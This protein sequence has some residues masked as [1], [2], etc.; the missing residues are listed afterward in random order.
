M[1]LEK[2]LAAVM[3]EMS[4]LPNESFPAQNI[5]PLLDLTLLDAQATCPQ[6]QA[7]SIKA[8][9][10]S[11]AAV[12]VLPD[13]LQWIP[14]AGMDIRRATVINFP[15]GNF[16]QKEVFKQFENIMNHQLV[17]EIDYVFPYQKYLDN[18]PSEALKACEQ[19]YRACSDHQIIFKVILETG[20]FPSCEL[21][22]QASR[23]VLAHGCDFLKTSTGKISAGASIPAVYAL[24][25]AIQDGDCACGI[26]ISGGVKTKEQASEY[27][28]LA[29]YMMQRPVKSTWFRIGASSLLDELL[30]HGHSL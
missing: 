30:D 1:N 18:E 3:E 6:I 24:L 4:F 10:Y 11:V 8:Q 12:C 28:Q 2:K 21:I 27:I 7:L 16:S 9:T 15:T 19:L 13:H 23:A 22:Y 5:I 25:L 20:A 17:H 29:E 14:E 26:K